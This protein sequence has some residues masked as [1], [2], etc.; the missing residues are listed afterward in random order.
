MTLLEAAPQ[1]M[2]LKPSLNDDQS[3]KIYLIIKKSA[4]RESDRK[5][6]TQTQRQNPYM[7]HSLVWS[8][9]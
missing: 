6:G 8:H 5:I 9:G 4:F 3:T 2:R 7:Q 1:A